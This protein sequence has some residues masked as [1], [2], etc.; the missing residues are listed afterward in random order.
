[1]ANQGYGLLKR[2]LVLLGRII[3]WFWWGIVK[4]MGTPLKSLPETLREGIIDD[5]HD[6][7]LS[8]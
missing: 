4:P 1:M 8:F 2:W 5:A 7:H 3:A 6:E